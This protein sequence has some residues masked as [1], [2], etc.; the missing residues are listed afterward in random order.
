MEATLIELGTMAECVSGTE[1]VGFV[2][3]KQSVAN[4]AHK[5]PAEFIEFMQYELYERVWAWMQETELPAEVRDSIDMCNMLNLVS[6]K[7]HSGTLTDL[8]AAELPISISEA[9]N[10]IVKMGGQFLG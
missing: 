6:R 9:A 7:I 2:G 1:S 10:L 5:I 3:F 4:T 8:D